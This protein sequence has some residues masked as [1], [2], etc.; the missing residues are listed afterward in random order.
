MEWYQALI[1]FM[2]AVVVTYIMV[3]ISKHIAWS[4]G[5]IDYPGNRRVNA[6]PIPRCGGIALY[7]GMSMACLTVFVG[8]RCFGWTFKE[9][10]LIEGIN[11]DMLFIGVTLMFLVG[12]IDDVVQLPALPKLAGQILA[13]IVVVLSG[14]SIGG[15]RTVIAGDYVALGWLDY[16]LTV[17]YLVVFVNI[18]NLIDGLDGLASGLIAIVAFSLMFLVWRRGSYMLV[19][20]CL[21]LIGCC[22]AFLRFNF[23]PASIFMGDSGS[24]LLGLLVGIIS[25]VGVVRTQGLIV[26][27]IP[28]VIA[29]VPLLDAASAFIRRLRGRQN[30]GQADLGHVHHRLMRAGLS[31][32]R[33]VA[34][35]WFCSAVLGFVGCIMIGVSGP[36]RWLLFALL[37]LVMF[38]V[39]WRFGLF[40]PVLKHHY[41]HS[42]RRVPRVQDI[43]DSRREK[44]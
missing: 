8:M 36:R 29:G 22:L 38:F 26:M 16:P 2:V 19:F 20:A 44:K 39:V 4:L 34:V 30:P 7:V 12:L 31:Q 24:H 32:K 41:D 1:V 27:L 10:Y 42:H 3:P 43:F 17:A 11:F 35:L 9:S 23:F 25:V 33:A 18:T 6:K 14:V 13:A 37:A 40:S 15:V 21:A 28:L 5:A